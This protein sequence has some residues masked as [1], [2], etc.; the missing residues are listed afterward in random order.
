MVVQDGS[1]DSSQAAQM[2]PAATANEDAAMVSYI[3]GIVT[4]NCDSVAARVFFE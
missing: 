4:L 2:F 1:L 3:D